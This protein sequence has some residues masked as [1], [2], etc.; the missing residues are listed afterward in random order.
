MAKNKQSTLAELVADSAP[1]ISTVELGEHSVKIQ[2][3]TGRD[4]FEIAVQEEK[5][6]RWD[7]MLWI[8]LQGMVDPP[9]VSVE[10]VEQ[11]KPEWIVK[12][13][14]ALMKLSGIATDEEEAK[15]VSPG[16]N[17]SGGS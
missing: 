17:D 16:A 4:R 3:L 1:E 8:C 10:D 11:I 5:L 2:A 15:N 6:S 14:T 13:A 9:V 7:L 12:I